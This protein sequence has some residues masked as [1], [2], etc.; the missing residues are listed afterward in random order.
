MRRR[1]QPEFGTAP[2]GA[3]V[4]LCGARTRAGTPCRGA[5]VR[6]GSGRCRMHGGNAHLTHSGPANAN[7]RGGT[8]RSSRR[9]YKVPA[10]LVSGYRR[11]LNDAQIGE[12]R[13]ELAL[14]Q[15]LI[16]RSLTQL[17]SGF[18]IDTAREA[19]E[20]FIVAVPDQR[21]AA[22]DNLRRAIHGAAGNERVVRR[23]T[24]LLEGARRL[25]DSALKR[26]T[27]ATNAMTRSEAIAQGNALVEAVTRNVSDPGLM[28]RIVDDVQRVLGHT[29]APIVH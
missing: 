19:F 14:T 26:E 4:P 8:S 27:A 28:R 17:E 24:R 29:T 20:I 5:S 10:A 1:T 16:Q 6:G 22:L 23:L 25:S 18:D 13:D 9:R 7:W 12:L 21:E 2:H 11:S 15:A 3:R